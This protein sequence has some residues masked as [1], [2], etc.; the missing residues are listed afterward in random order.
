MSDPT[1]TDTPSGDRTGGTD[2]THVTPDVDPAPRPAPGTVRRMVFDLAATRT[3]TDTKNIL[4]LRYS[5][6]IE[7]K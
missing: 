7:K 1:Q 5:K 4:Y 3:Y 2:T 6:K